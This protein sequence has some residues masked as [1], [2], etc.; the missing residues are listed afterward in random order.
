[1]K[2]QS[3]KLVIEHY[4]RLRDDSVAAQARVQME[5]A[6][7]QR[8]LRTLVQHRQEQYQRARD[9]QHTPVSTTQ[10]LLQTRF[11]S[12]LGEAITLQTQRIADFQLRI[13]SCRAQVLADQQR[14][15]AIESIEHQRE[16]R[17]LHQA[18]RADQLATDERAANRHAQSIRERLDEQAGQPQQPN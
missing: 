7:A 1:M 13:E 2:P 12:K 10:L 6:A 3:L 9:S 15:K 14:F 8:T 11:S 16:L 18:A 5:F 4:R 17:A